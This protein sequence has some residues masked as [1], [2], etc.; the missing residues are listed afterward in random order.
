M[1]KVSEQGVALWD[2]V[3]INSKLFSPHQTLIKSIAWL[4]DVWTIIEFWAWTWADVLE[5]AKL[6]YHV[7]YSDFSDIAIEK[8]KKNI[9]SDNKNISIEKEDVLNIKHNDNKFDLVYSCWLIE[10]FSEAQRL[11]ILSDMI[12]I[13]D[14]YVI[15]DFPNKFSLHNV[16]KKILMS[17]GKWPYGW[18]TEFSYWEFKDYLIKNFKGIEIVHFYW[19]E[20]LPIPRIMKQKFKFFDYQHNLINYFKWSIWIVIRK[21]K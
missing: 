7:T 2:K 17:I 13:S 20:L 14:K 9:G 15:I 11:K 18:E 5:L 8:F 19:R 16:A 4:K 12:R 1:A 6:Q 21:K 10:H 3:W